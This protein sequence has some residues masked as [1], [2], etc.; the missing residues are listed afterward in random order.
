M[1]PLSPQFIKKLRKHGI[2]IPEDQPEERLDDPSF[3]APKPRTLPAEE[4]QRAKADKGKPKPR[5]DYEHGCRLTLEALTSLG[6][7]I[8]R[9]D[10]VP[11]TGFTNIQQLTFLRCLLKQG[12]ISSSGEGKGT[13]YTLRDP[14]LPQESPQKRRKTQPRGPKPRKKPPGV[15][16]KGLF[17]HPYEEDRGFAL[18]LASAKQQNL[19]DVVRDLFHKVC[20]GLITDQH[21][22]FRATHNEAL[23][24]MAVRIEELQT[25]LREMNEV[26]LQRLA[27]IRRVL[28][29]FAFE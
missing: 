12:K 23:A 6:R 13:V 1:A 8:R 26:Q 21:F 5:L 17:F 3:E 28:S 25:E 9:G 2:I 22:A 14:S 11:L 15:S 27:E 19:Q 10:L 18:R 7:P 4:P 24:G 16:S 29:R 20:E